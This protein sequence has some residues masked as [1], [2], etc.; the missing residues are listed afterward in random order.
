MFLSYLNDRKS[1]LF[2][3]IASVG[4]MNFILLLDNGIPV[5]LGSVLYFDLLFL[6]LFI[7]FI[8]WRYFMEMK[9][10]KE[11]G[12]SVN[13]QGNDWHVA[14]PDAVYK[15]DLMTKALL[16]EA[17][18]NF[19][20]QLAEMRR[21]SMQEG[22]YTAAWVHEV[23]TPL[24]AMK[25]VID[26]HRNDPNMRRIEGEW[27]RLYLLVDRQLSISR[28][29]SLESDY[30]LEKT[31]LQ[32]LVALEVRELASW[33]M[34]KNIAVE[35]EGEALEV[36]TDIKWCRFIFRQLFTNAIK[37]SPV[38]GTITISMM[39]NETGH[40]LLQIQ[41]E[42]PGI[43]THDLPRIFEKGFTGGM[44]R[45]H[46]AASGLGLYLAQTVAHK[47]GMTLMVSAEVGEGTSFVISFPNEND[48][49]KLKL[50]SAGI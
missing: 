6:I 21:F 11:L 2:F 26:E 24:T 44:G 37:Y 35:F 3:Y 14:L 29:P 20:N 40:T 9:F 12:R 39:E 38:G 33:C 42:G 23:K 18:V 32:K 34:E 36:L 4:L 5:E 46:N 15:Q 19:S 16:E 28:L 1:W 47:M 50:Q 17:A 31:N 13:E 10:T 25:L 41:D 22:E 8:I 48:F 7:V 30:V 45:I 27:L 43:E 49:D